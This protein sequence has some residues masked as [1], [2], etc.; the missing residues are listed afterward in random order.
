E[1]ISLALTADPQARSQLLVEYA[2]RRLQEF[3]T[4]VASG[5]KV[6]SALVAETLDNLLDNVQG[7]LATSQQASEVNVA[8]AV[9]QI[10]N[11]TKSAISQA[12]AV[13]PDTA[14]VLNQV[15][16]RADVLDQR[17]AVVEAASTPTSE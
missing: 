4:L 5:D 9:K 13:A 17:V 2:G 11:D 15:L 16:S 3:N 7:A 8:P 14:P 1:N 10:L 12:A 6:D